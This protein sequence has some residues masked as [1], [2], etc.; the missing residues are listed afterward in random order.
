MKK[1]LTSVLALC[2]AQTS[3]A[4]EV[5]IDSIQCQPNPDVLVNL[6]KLD[7]EIKFS[8]PVPALKGYIE[9]GLKAD[10]SVTDNSGTYEFKNKGAKKLPN[11]QYGNLIQVFGPVDLYLKP[12]E[13]KDTEILYGAWGD[14]RSDELDYWLVKP[15]DGGYPL[16]CSASL[17]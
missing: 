14:I 7:V 11:K 4:D 10:V 16:L 3:Y 13:V 15:S 17:Q 8:K 2:L 1:L 6:E 5:T 9:Y 12:V